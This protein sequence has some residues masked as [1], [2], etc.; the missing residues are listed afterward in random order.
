MYKLSEEEHKKRLELYEAGYTDKEI[1]EQVHVAQ[2]A[3]W[4]WRQNNNLPTKHP[5]YRGQG[6][7]KGE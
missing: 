4:R 6:R 2:T 1:G 7:K 5:V 3:I